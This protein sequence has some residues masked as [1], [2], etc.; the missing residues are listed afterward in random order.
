MYQQILGSL[1]RQN[2]A[3]LLLRELLEEEFSLLMTRD[4]DGVMQVEFSIHELLRQL[5]LEKESVIHGLGGGKVRDYADMLPQE[6]GEPLRDLWQ[7]VDDNEQASARQATLNTQLSLGLLDQS[8]QLLNFL[9]SR[10]L[11]PQSSTYGRR[12]R[13]MTHRPEAAILSGRL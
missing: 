4:T 1:D 12:G 10:A 8:E 2:K 5:A 9:H 7:Q 13:V 3:L 11:P 6:Q